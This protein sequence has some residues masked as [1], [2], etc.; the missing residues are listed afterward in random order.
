[1]C[2]ETTVPTW[3]VVLPGRVRSSFDMRRPRATLVI[4]PKEP[5]EE[6]LS[7]PVAV[8]RSLAA[9][10][11]D[12]R[13]E[14]E[15]RSELLHAVGEVARRCASARIERLVNMRDYSSD[16]IRQK[17][18]MDGYAAKT[19]D[20]CVRRAAD[21]HLIND[22]R[23]ADVF[24]R[25]KLSAGWGMARIERELAR[26]GVEVSQLAG[27]PYEYLDPEDELSR[28]CEVARRKGVHG[29]HPYERLVRHL[30]SRGFAMGVSR[31]AAR[32][33][34]DESAQDV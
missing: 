4:H 6:Q 14:V 17:L 29:A 19:I 3:E 25:S 13:L 34:M 32:V 27:W 7:I 28:A 18:S 8:G 9:R 21:A 24:V 16:E 15:F 31:R 26:R 23:Y 10:K 22:V 20:A 5:D 2:T 11:D 12:G 30:C 33:V 1:M